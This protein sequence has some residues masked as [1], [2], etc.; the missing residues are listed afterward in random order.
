M[1]ESEVQSLKALQPI[2]VTLSG[3]IMLASDVQ[4]SKAQLPILVTL[5]P[6]ISDGISSSVEEPIYRSILAVPSSNTV[7]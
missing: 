3:I 5:C 7:Y 4:P 2:S 1:L 6:S